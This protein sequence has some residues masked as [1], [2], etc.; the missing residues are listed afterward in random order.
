MET[1]VLRDFIRLDFQA[2]LENYFLS[3]T[4]PWFLLTSNSGKMSKQGDSRVGFAN[5]VYFKKPHAECYEELKYIFDQF[6][7]KT[8]LPFSELLR[9]RVG[10]QLPDNTHSH[11][12]PH[13]DHLDQNHYTAC[14]YITSCSGD[15]VIFNETIQDIPGPLE[16]HNA[17]EQAKFTIKERHSPERGKM[18][19]FLGKHYHASSSPD[20]GQLRIVVTYNWI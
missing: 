11:H 2:D 1:I 12:G 10:L 14:F 13:I 8:L 9:I 7:E 6:I 20:N 4:F 18:I 17:L 16:Y 5:T 19:A 15:T 3:D